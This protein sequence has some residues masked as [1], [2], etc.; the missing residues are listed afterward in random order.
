MIEPKAGQ[1]LAPTITTL[2]DSGE[3]RQFTTGAVRDRAAGKGRYDLLPMQL[4]MRLA[5][6]YE[7]GA[8]KYSDRNW[9]KGMPFS[10]YI[11]AAMRHLVKYI[12]GWN[13]EDHL[14]A[15][16]WNLAAVMF[17]E[18][19]NPDLQDLPERQE[20]RSF[21]WVIHKPEDA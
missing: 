13:D 16:I 9:E 10:V 17:Q 2:K 5:R 21:K 14:A 11:D 20:A 4:L 18:E 6:H 8:M 15:A 12:A 1:S 3:R 7:A 19:K